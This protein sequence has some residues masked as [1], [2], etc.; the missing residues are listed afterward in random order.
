MVIN[1]GKHARDTLGAVLVATGLAI[2]LPLFGNPATAEEHD[3]ERH[4]TVDRPVVVVRS[5][6][7]HPNLTWSVA[8]SRS[9]LGVQTVDLTPELREHFGVPRQA[10]VLVARIVE[11]S[12]AAAS[13]LEV[14]DIISA[15]D[16]EDIVS[17]SDL[18]R[19]VGHHDSGDVIDLEIWRQGTILQ[20][21][22]TLV[23]RQRPAVDIRQ[24]HL[25]QARLEG[26]ELSETELEGIIELEAETL[27]MAIERLNEELDSPEWH[28]RVHTFKQHQ[29]TLMKRIELLEKQLKDLEEELQRLAADD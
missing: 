11:E 8:G 2:C 29:G 21:Q 14:G 3:Q 10:G 23:E 6:T 28:A 20:L 18:A 17:P 22:A 5:A 9:F 12:P 13:N 19:A 24:F 15:V 4:V 1:T 27:N 25:P 16:G 26:L 7:N